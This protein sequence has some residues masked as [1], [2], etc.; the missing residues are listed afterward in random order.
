MSKYAALTT[1]L[2]SLSSGV[3]HTT[4]REVE[5][6][7]GF[8]LPPSAREYRAWWENEAHGTHS[9]ARSWLRTGWETA[10]VNLTGETLEFRR[11]TRKGVRKDKP[12][13]IKR[14]LEES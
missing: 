12:V 14:P 8:P 13:I 11:R 7:L 10:K 2:L 4:F 6:I 9:H 3:W 5:R 1:H